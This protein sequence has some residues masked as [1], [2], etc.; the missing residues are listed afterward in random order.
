MTLVASPV[1]PQSVKDLAGAFDLFVQASQALERRH[2]ELAGQID[3]LNADL[4]RAHDRLQ[5]LINALPAGVVLIENGLVTHFNKAALRWLPDLATQQAWTLPTSWSPG[6]GPT[7]YTVE[8]AGQR[9]SLQIERNERGPQTLIQIQDITENLRR[10]A[11]IERLDR[12][13]AMGKMSAGI[14]HQFRTPLSTAMLYA[15]HLVEGQLDA[16]Q[17]IDFAQRLHGQLLNLEKLAGQML[18]FIKPGLRQPELVRLTELAEHALSQVVALAQDKSLRIEHVAEPAAAQCVISCDQAALVSALVAILENAIE[19]S[20]HGAQ[21]LL[22]TTQ[23][24]MRAEITVDD[25]GPGIAGEMLDCLFEPFSTSRSAGTGL[26][27]SIAL[28]TVRQHRGDIHA[29]NREPRGAR[30]LIQLPCLSSF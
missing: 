18:Q 20:E 21:V 12:L 28:N 17:R 26:G 7:E 2:Q 16:S 10:L 1:T 15:S 14:A 8:L 5:G 22:R 13:A 3:A 29:S 24:G 9:H 11:E 25:W 19:V 4:V 30:F 6:S 27:L 23:Q